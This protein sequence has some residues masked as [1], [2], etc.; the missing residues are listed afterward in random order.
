MKYRLIT[1]LLLIFI[2][3]PAV[4]AQ[5]NYCEC[6]ASYGDWE[7][8][9]KV[10]IGTFE[11]SSESAMYQDFTGLG[12]IEL[13]K[14]ENYQLQFIT[15]KYSESDRLEVYIDY[16]NDE[17]FQ[18]EEKLAT[19]FS[20]EASRE[21]IG[22]CQ[23]EIPIEAVEAATRMRVVL[24]D[25]GSEY[26]NYSNGCGTF[27][28]GEVEDYT[29]MIKA[30]TTA[31][32]VDFFANTT[33]I[34]TG[35]V[36][37]FFDKSNLI[38]TQWKWEFTPNTI[39]YLE[40]T[41]STSQ[42][43]VV[44]FHEKGY[45]EVKLTAD[46]FIG[47]ASLSK[48][49]YVQV[50]TFSSPKS[51]QATADGS[52]VDLSWDI[53]NVPSWIAYNQSVHTCFNTVYPNTMRGTL[54]EEEQLPFSFPVSIDK[55]S[56]AFYY[57]AGNPWPDNK[58]KFKVFNYSDNEL[59]YESEYIEAVH[60][61]E[62]VHELPQAITLTEPF[63]IA[64]EAK[65]PSGMPA[66]MARKRNA[67]DVHSYTYNSNSN[68]WEK[69]TDGNFGFEVFIRAGVTHDVKEDNLSLIGYQILRDEELIHTLD[70]PKEC[71]YTD[72]GLSNGNY[73]YSVKALYSG[74]VVS[75]P[76]PPIEVAVD[77]ALAE[78][79]V[80]NPENISIKQMDTYVFPTNV[81][82]GESLDIQFM[83][84]NEGK[85]T[86]SLNEI[87]IDH[88]E[89]SLSNNAA[90]NLEEG[91]SATIT[92]TFSPVDEGKETANITILS[93]DHNESPFIFNV[94]AIGGQDQWTYMLYL[95][96]D[97][98]GLD[99]LKDLNEWEVNGSL[100]GEVNYLVLYDANDDNKDGIW[101]IK[102]DTDGMNYTLVS[103]KVSNQFGVD[104]NMSDP[105]VLEQYIL[106][107]KDNYP[108]QHY[109]LTMWDHGDGIFKKKQ[110]E[111]GFVGSMKLWEMSAAVEKFVNATGRPMDIIGFDVCLLGQVETA[112]QF[113]DLAKYVIAS[114]LSAPGDGWDYHN[115]FKVLNENAMIPSEDLAINIGETFISSYSPG[116]SS[117]Q[118][119]STHSVVS[120]QKLMDVLM[121]ELDLFS[122]KL[123]QHAEE[124][125][126]E[127]GSIKGRTWVATN[128]NG[129]SN[130]DHRDLGH[131]AE[132]V[133]ASSKLPQDLKDQA[134]IM[135]AAYHE[136]V[137]YN[138]YTG[139]QNKKASGMKIWMHEKVTNAGTAYQFYSNSN[140]YLRFGETKWLDY[141]KAYESPI[142][143]KV[144]VASYSVEHNSAALGESITF[145]DQ[146]TEYPSSWKWT[147]TPSEGCN[148]MKSKGNRQ[149]NPQVQ[150]NATGYYDVLLEVENN[151]G[152]DQELKKYCI[153]I[154]NPAL[155][156]ATNLSAEKT[157]TT[158]SLNWETPANSKDAS[159]IG[160][161]IYR[162]HEVIASLENVNTFKDEEA[163]IYEHTYYIQAIYT[164]AG[165][166]KLSGPSN[167]AN[168]EGE[169]NGY[170]ETEKEM[171]S[172]YPNPMS[173]QLNIHLKNAAQEANI[174][175]YNTQ[176]SLILKEQHTGSLLQLNTQNWKPGAYYIN[177][178]I[179]SYLFKQT[180]IK[181]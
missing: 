20:G 8:I 146:S 86:L 85:Q 118:T 41:S 28:Y 138:G 15:Q 82:V 22:N 77:N 26:S 44:Q 49:N 42:N 120:T 19:T 164:E 62:V 121:P 54:F 39:T 25:S 100:E 149:P 64:I 117:Y 87:T 102:K 79:E 131:F 137:V 95:Y 168:V 125:K 114:E 5:K 14:G 106:W 154:D 113:H 7:Y 127:Y 101:Y 93:N 133:I 145:T 47:S 163:G 66:N 177:I 33:S 181:Q 119:Y 96:E 30:I 16:N 144:P 172:I 171:F 176:G 31:P 11:N 24:Y 18:E 65:D 156:N 155:P 72:Y 80:F 148:F 27:D 69:Y 4:K 104:P 52:H 134:E 57:S 158:V 166:E 140:K 141:L 132:L 124:H 179:D 38:P 32:E 152:T 40:G 105:D 60:V 107:V 67:E 23:L 76:C 12:A 78:I 174:R 165:T 92:I 43:P 56:T 167:L 130:P 143:L 81:S 35:G 170:H 112:Y 178:I 74:D 50:R 90:S 46:N 88:P 109:G 29:I 48:S 157:A 122:I 91:E 98:Q 129:A 68:T 6:T 147:I 37:R 75:D 150:F 142:N 51:F 151:I 126:E 83:I 123:I 175:V 136:A 58:F 9:S 70:Q 21:G 103:E 173:D 180:V 135:L 116:G 169:P 3:S 159:L 84:K 71:R 108:A 59:I 160:Y 2:S 110:D 162:D 153:A 63:I 36:V 128:T 97:G 161:K 139:E 17:S 55:L 61:T 10:N 13:Y 53:P 45:Y 115:A 1:L 34:Y 111:K 94:K 73:T 99:G 89:F